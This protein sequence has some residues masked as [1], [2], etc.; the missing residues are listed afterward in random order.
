[1]KS[2][3][4]FFL[5]TPVFLIAQ[6]FNLVQSTDLTAT[7]FI[8]IDSYKNTY[9]IKD[10][11]LHKTGP[12]G[13]YVFNDFQLGSITTVDIINPLKIV[14]FYED[15]NT[16]VFLDNRLSEIERINFNNLPE[17][18]NPSTATNAGNNR[19][20][21]FNIVSQQLEL[22]NYHANTK[23]TVSQ[24][25]AGKV[26]SQASNFNYCYTLTETKL[27]SFNVY[28]SMLSE[29]EAKGFTKIVQ[30]EK[31]VIGLKGNELFFISENSINPIKLPVYENPIKELQLS[32]DFL[33]IYDGK[34]LHSF[35]ITQ[36]KQ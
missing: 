3:L 8:G 25:F 13:S 36:P 24:P 33:Y 23:I 12:D 20:W 5:F 26:L 14:L 11:V 17:Y 34:K 6:E 15:M 7:K 16:V 2:I 19:L 31:S 28:G 30:H 27:R 18:T 35:S 21:V 1:M 4:L 29:I 9:F 10:R 32:K 22:F